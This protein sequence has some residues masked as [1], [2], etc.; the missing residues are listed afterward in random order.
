MVAALDE[1]ERSLRFGA[2][3]GLAALRDPTAL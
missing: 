1:P 3:G 2:V